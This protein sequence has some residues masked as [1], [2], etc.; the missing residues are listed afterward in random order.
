MNNDKNNRIGEISQNKSG[1]MMRI[2]KYN[3]CMDI[4]VEFEETKEKI[5]CSYLCFKKGE[6][7]S[8]FSPT[9]YDVGIIGL[10][11]SKDNNGKI[12]KS[13]R[14]WSEMLRRSYSKKFKEKNPTYKDV[15]CCEEWLLYSNFK[16]WYDENFY[17]IE[18]EIIDLDKDILQK[19]NKIYSPDTCVFVPHNINM[20]FTKNNSKRGDLPIGVSGYNRK[21]VSRCSYDK[22]GIKINKHLGYYETTKQAFQSYKSFKEQLI[23]QVA[24]EYKGKI[25][26]KLYKAM[27]D[28]VVD[29]TD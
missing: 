27:Y 11:K 10:E 2:V 8:H 23:R 16:K 17:Q 14:H 5:K 6:V 4:I 1:K 28:W 25:P 19:G 12:I 13:Y 7:K 24:D 21:Y 26:N 20:L 15:T 9:V 3:S 29:I 22:N 18:N